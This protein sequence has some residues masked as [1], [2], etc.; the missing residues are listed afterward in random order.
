MCNVCFIGE[1]AINGAESDDANDAEDDND[2]ALWMGMGIEIDVFLKTTYVDIVMRYWSAYK[3]A[4]EE[5][6]ED[7]RG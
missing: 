5:E 2:C 1:T 4:G 6:I 7:E 3:E